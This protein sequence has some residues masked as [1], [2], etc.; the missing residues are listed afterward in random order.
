[1]FGNFLS[2]AIINYV[3]NINGDLY[4]ITKPNVS[5]GNAISLYNRANN[6]YMRHRFGVI[7][8]EAKPAAHDEY[9]LYDSSFIPCLSH[10]GVILKCS[11]PGLTNNVISLVDGRY[12]ISSE[13]PAVFYPLAMPKI[14]DT[15][16]LVNQKYLI[17]PANNGNKEEF[18]LQ[19]LIPDNGFV[20][21]RF[22]KIYVEMP[23]TKED[24]LYNNDSSFVLQPFSG[25]F[26]L[27]CTSAGLQDHYVVIN[28][29]GDLL[30]KP[31][32]EITTSEKSAIQKDHSLQQHEQ[33]KCATIRLLSDNSAILTDLRLVQSDHHISEIE[34]FCSKIAAKIS[35][36]E[37]K[38]DVCIS[39]N[40]N[41]VN[42]IKILEEFA[43]IKLNHQ[44]ANLSPLLSIVIPVYNEER[45]ISRCLNSLFSQTFSSFEIII[46]NDG[47]TDRTGEII[48][49]FS[50]RDARISVIN[51]DHKGAGEARNIGLANIKG[52]Y[53]SILDADDEY[54]PNML[55]TLYSQAA[56]DNLDI[57]V[58]RSERI[59]GDDESSREKMPWTIAASYLPR[60]RVFSAGDCSD[61]IF[62]IFNG[63]TWDKLFSADFV[64]KAGLKFQN[65]AFSNDAKF[66]FTALCSANRISTTDE[67]LVTHRY[68]DNSIEARRYED[69]VNFIEVFRSIKA[70][71][72]ETRNSSLFGLSFKNWVISF[73]NW[74]CETSKTA[75]C[76]DAIIKAAADFFEENGITENLTRIYKDK[77]TLWLTDNFETSVPEVSV[78][79]PV[80]NSEAYLEETISSLISQTM[81]NFE[82]ICID[83]GSHDR[84]FEILINTAKSDKRFRIVRQDNSGAGTARNKGLELARGR[85]LAFIDSDDIYNQTFLEKMLCKARRFDLDVVVCRYI[86]FFDTYNTEN[87][88]PRD[89]N[90]PLLP[91]KE[92]FS[93]PD[94]KDNFFQMFIPV[95]WNKFFKKEFIMNHHI[96]FQ[97]LINS[98]DTFFVY[99]ALLSAAAISIIDERLI[100]YRMRSGSLVRTRRAAPDCYIKAQ[101]ALEKFVT[102]LGLL[103]DEGFRKS[104][105]IRIKENTKWN[106]K[107]INSAS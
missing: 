54:D 17:C 104:F 79:M 49:D 64:R 103:Q 52:K 96:R 18:S 99:R 65:T 27:R 59:N 82:V 53:I 23:N 98:N 48:T 86:R 1:M 41:L 77:D 85:Y 45:Y 97:E 62:Q 5:L 50:S 101:A 89:I 81:G 76:R 40:F 84:S 39:N 58:C 66:T 26:L 3:I 6:V 30:I 102:E 80:F 15:A 8:S 70:W 31:Q 25:E 95:V 16:E 60:N 100:R 33:Y 7:C 78:I 90:M 38:L 83:D 74:Q 69:P 71:L 72:E 22:G 28:N 73:T 20:R 57:M 106:K 94:I 68:H 63:W 92:V 42:R 44:Y 67:C 21:H 46:V 93:L 61:Y 10:N 29:N 34:R 91:K 75:S 12:I 24:I 36:V 11:N 35:N 47:S 88:P 4:H 14:G 87:I 19:S 43:L 37:Q 13:N 56:A 9:F 55:T 105:N 32:S 107:M 51:I 2:N